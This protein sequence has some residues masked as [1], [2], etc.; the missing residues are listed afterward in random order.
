MRGLVRVGKLQ[1]GRSTLGVCVLTNDTEDRVGG[2]ILL[3]ETVE[4]RIGHRGRALGAELGR[5]A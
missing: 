5:R 4:M 3:V 1:C 2:W